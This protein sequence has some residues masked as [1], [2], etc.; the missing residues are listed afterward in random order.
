M[1]L[2]GNKNG[3]IPEH[4]KPRKRLTVCCKEIVRII[5]ISGTK[6]KKLN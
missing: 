3:L 1:N 6:F 2:C 4:K 5:N